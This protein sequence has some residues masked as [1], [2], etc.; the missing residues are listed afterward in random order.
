[1][2]D[3]AQEP[4]IGVFILSPIRIYR[5]GLSHVLAEEP[6]VRVLGTAA[7]PEDAGARLGDAA[8]EVVLVDVGAGPDLAG[9]RHLARYADLRVIALGVT[10]DPAAVIACAE[11][12]IA[13]Y[14]TPHS[15]LTELVQTIRAA[16]RGDFS[17]PPHIA[18]GLLRRLAAVAP[19]ESPAQRAQLTAREREIVSLIRRGLSNKEI[20]RRLGIQ[21]ATVKNHVHN[22]LDKL[23]VTRR[24]DAAAALE[25][26]PPAPRRGRPVP[27]RI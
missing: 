25:P 10:E 13:G 27:A 17:C 18:A 8:L 24:A 2:N 12:G 26:F 20:A 6:A 3:Q 21:V 14:A 5:E 16:A 11:A 1:M 22:I 19:R 7:A 9:L 15:S 23:G 4:G